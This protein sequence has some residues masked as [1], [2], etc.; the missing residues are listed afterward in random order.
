MSLLQLSKKV[1]HLLELPVSHVL[2]ANEKNHRG[3]ARETPVLPHKVEFCLDIVDEEGHVV[4]QVEV[5][6]LE[7]QRI[8]QDCLSA[9]PIDFRCP[10]SPHR[11]RRPPPKT[12]LLVDPQVFVNLA[13]TVIVL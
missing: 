3:T 12:Q 10:Q 8:A 2:F 4:T 11:T 5:R 6:H 1:E 9:N 7:H 13:R